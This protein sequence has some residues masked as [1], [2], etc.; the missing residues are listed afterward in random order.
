MALLK[1]G[2]NTKL[3]RG[4]ASFNLPA[5]RTCPGR[6]QLCERICYATSGFFQFPKIKQVH[7]TA[8]ANTR[9][10]DFVALVNDEIRRRR[11]IKAV[12]IHAAGDFYS[13]EYIR[14]W[15]SIASSNPST[16]FWAYTR[17]WRIP[18]LRSDLE[19]FASLSN[20]ELFASI[21]TETKANNEQPP[22]WLRQADVV[23]NWVNTPTDTVECPNQ[24][25]DSITC[26][27]CT[28]CFKPAGNRKTHV[29]FK[30]H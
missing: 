15:H 18:A 11:S 28:Y 19:R 12:R 13:D 7:E 24:K 1:L 22:G 5:V 20:V 17:S 2:T 29:V 3:G 14:R 10:P 4:I 23:D 27:K 16:K 8:W 26:A 25:N 9:H 30:V 21:D 6:T